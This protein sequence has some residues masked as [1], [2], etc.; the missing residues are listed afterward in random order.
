M[1]LIQT[2]KKGQLRVFTCNKTDRYFKE[3]YTISVLTYLPSTVSNI[4][5]NSKGVIAHQFTLV[6]STT[7]WI[8]E[9]SF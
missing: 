7:L 6:L 8:L 3:G 9:R 2:I 4:I 1:I 5:Q